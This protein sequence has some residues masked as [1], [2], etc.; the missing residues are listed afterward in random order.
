MTC[1]VCIAAVGEVHLYR[2]ENMLGSCHN[3]T[4]LKSGFEVVF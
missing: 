3:K 4:Y 2:E 1:F